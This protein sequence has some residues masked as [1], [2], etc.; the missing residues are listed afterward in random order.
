M[1]NTCTLQYIKMHCSS[2]SNSRLACYYLK[3]KKVLPFDDYVPQ[4]TPP[5]LREVNN[6]LP[7]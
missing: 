6:V 4:E 1:S 5:L 7:T 3:A 2:T